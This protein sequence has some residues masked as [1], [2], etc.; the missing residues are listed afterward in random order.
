LVVAYGDAECAPNEFT[1]APA[2]AIPIALSR[3]GLSIKD[4]S[5]WEINEAF[6]VVVRANEQVTGSNVIHDDTNTAH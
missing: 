4:I 2:L 3:A 6:S 1:I 5:L